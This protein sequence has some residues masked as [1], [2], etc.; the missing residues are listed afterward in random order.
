MSDILPDEAA[1][2]RRAED[3]ARAIFGQ[4]GYQEIRT[5]I[6]EETGLFK[7]SI[8]EE[9]DI[10]QKQM[11]SFKDRGERDVSL[12]P[13]GTA[14]VVRAYLEH[15]LGNVLPVQRLYYIGPM[16]R[17]ERPQAGRLRQFHQIGAEAIG[18]PSPYLDAEIISLMMGILAACGLGDVELKLNTLGCAK[19]KKAFEQALKKALAP[20]A[21]K[22]G[23]LCEDCAK[24]YE[25]N[26]LRL[27]DCKNDGCRK[28]LVAAPRI[29]DYLC[30]SCSGQFDRIKEL[31]DAA[32]IKYTLTPSLVRGLDYYTGVVFEAS[33]KNLGSQ[34][35]VA[36]GGRYDNLIE[37]LGG[38][39]TPACGFAIGTDRVLLAAKGTEIKK[40]GL[41]LFF[42][43]LGDEA[44]KKA[45]SILSALRTKG[46][47]CQMGLD[48]KSL[49]SQMRLA[50]RVGAKKVLILGDEELKK[51]VALLRD[52]ETKTQKE[53][54]LEDVT[55][56]HLW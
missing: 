38:S 9:T 14:P 21:G 49:K 42:I 41:D 33:H 52:M 20:L 24:R 27:F 5:P 29:T 48:E 7:R 43:G 2:W 13:E 53:I 22:V 51:G 46:V 35:A 45:F 54:R 55:D 25:K 32:G 17:N 37:G 18:S 47:A 34:D 30:G 6:L 3:N 16:F 39:S 10:V 50:D 26:I 4:Y 28:A 56:T 23:S 1:V 31:L 36:A 40:A 44:Q 19:D 8:G 12:R 15:S 11:Y